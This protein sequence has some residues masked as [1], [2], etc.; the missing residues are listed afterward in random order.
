MAADWDTLKEQQELILSRE[1]VI[2]KILIGFSTAILTAAVI[3]SAASVWAI[4]G[5]INGIKEWITVHIAEVEYGSKQHSAFEK[6][7]LKLEEF[8]SAG[9][10]FTKKDGDLL[11]HEDRRL[12]DR[13]R[14]LEDSRIRIESKLDRIEERSK[15]ILDK[16]GAFKNAVGAPHP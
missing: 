6:R 2:K 16:L 9:D 4:F 10:R 15:D 3:S 8:A 12:S 5:E 11:A 14:L 1:G 7:I 13:I